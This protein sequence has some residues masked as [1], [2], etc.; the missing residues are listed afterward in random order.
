MA[1]T[2]HASPPARPPATTPPARR[3]FLVGMGALFFGALVGL[4]PA[5]SG[6]AVLLDPLRRKKPAGSF[7]RITNLAALADDGVPRQFPVVAERLD[8]WN[9][10]LEPIGAVYLSR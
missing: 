6:L 4:V 10:S 2:S 8:A 3:N 1:T 5:A 9:R 7:I